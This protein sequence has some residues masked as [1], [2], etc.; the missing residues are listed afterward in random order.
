MLNDKIFNRVYVDYKVY[1]V[2]RLKDKYGFKIKLIFNDGSDEIRQ[3]GGFTKKKEANQ[4]RDNTIADLKNHIYVVY[5]RIKF[6]DY[7]RYWLDKAMKP[8]IT[9]NTYMSYRNVVE[10]YVVAFFGSLYVSQ[11]NLGHIQKFYNYVTKKSKS[12]ARLAKTVM[13][14]TME[15][16]KEKNLIKVNPT[17]NVNLPKCVEEKPYGVLEI[18]VEKTFS[19]DQTKI[20]I[21]ASKE[22]PIYLHILFAVLMGL[23]KQEIN[24]IKYNDIDFINRK[25]YLQRQ[26]G[27]D[28]TK[29]KEDCP[30]KTYT[31]QE[32]KLKSYSSERVLDIP[33]MVFEAILEE[34]KKYERNRNRRINDKNNPFIDSGFVCCST[35]GHPRSKGFHT[36]YYNKLL[37]NNNLPK[38]RFHDLRHTYTTLL[39][40]NN[41]DLKAVSELLGHA[42][43]I[44]T[45]GVYFDKD[46]IVIDCNEELEQYISRVRPEQNL[47]ENEFID[48][49]LD[50]NLITSNYINK[51][52]KKANYN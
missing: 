3:I 44:I 51:V 38:I 33:D 1:S 32:I 13:V 6:L 10:N 29:S 28:P 15:Y 31:K 7:I 42:S 47:K 22:T 34:R 40:M 36:R 39:L 49:D 46:K 24:G 4:E 9:Y 14:T 48:S 2:L 35:Y 45:A 26:L 27:V 19:V 16:A 23:R 30:K 5:Q 52:S 25:L 37:E 11:L 50:T 18:D 12:V 21:S 8:Y 20:L 41:Y 17:I 43:T